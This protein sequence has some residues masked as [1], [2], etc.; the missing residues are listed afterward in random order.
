MKLSL[1]L[2]AALGIPAAH[3]APPPAL[4]PTRDVLVNYDLAAPGRAT[5]TYQL[6]YDAAGRLAR[7]NDPAH[8]TWFLVD[9]AAGHA[10]LVLPML[11]TVVDAPDISNISQEITA[12]RN[13]RFTTLGPGHYAGLACEKYLVINPQG[14]ADAC[15]T[16]DGVALNFHGRDT[17]GSAEVTATSVT[18]APAN[19]SDFSPPEGFGSVTLPPGALEQLLRQQ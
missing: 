9:L 12:A 8:G 17:H 15:L 3:A 11:H 2:L 4:L 6:E 14:T 5:T 1:L 10:Q 7:I 16:P 13:A 19:P 18:Y